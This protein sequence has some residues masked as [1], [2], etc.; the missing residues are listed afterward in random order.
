M[1]LNF[2]S[3]P[4]TD[5]VYTIGTRTYV[6]DGNA[7]NL[8]LSPLTA[9][10]SLSV[11]KTGGYGDLLYNPS[12]GVFTY[13][14]PST[15]EIRSAFS[16]G[17]GISLT[18]GAVSVDT[19]VVRTS[20]TQTVSAKIFEDI[21]LNR[22]IKYQV[23]TMTSGVVDSNNGTIQKLNMS[24]STYISDNMLPGTSVILM[25]TGGS[26]FPIYWPSMTWVGQLGNV[27]PALTA[28]DTVVLWK[29]DTTLYGAWVGS[30]A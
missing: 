18:N 27:T 19:T 3:N 5:Q 25:I 29:I 14:G 4:A 28:S 13:A 9:L 10:N 7:W 26:N 24:G 22:N 6:F 16:A 17:S 20:G 1:S 21:T 11:T 23:H 15:A 30:S 12:N 8:A 2:P